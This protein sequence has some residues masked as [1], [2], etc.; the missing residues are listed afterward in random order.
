[1]NQIR[2][3]KVGRAG[4]GVSRGGF[5]G[6]RCLRH[7]WPRLRYIGPS[8]LNT[9][10][11]AVFYMAGYFVRHTFEQREDRAREIGDGLIMHG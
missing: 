10:K 9:R 3:E 7:L 5:L 2:P 4:G 8:A 1:M 11:T 6:R